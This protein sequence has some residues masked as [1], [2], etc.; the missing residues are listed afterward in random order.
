MAIS[1]DYFFTCSAKP[2]A[3]Y[4]ADYSTVFSQWVA[5]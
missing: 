3:F 2:A 4:L 5:M 1:P